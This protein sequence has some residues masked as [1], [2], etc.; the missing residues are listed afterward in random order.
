MKC[1]NCG[2]RNRNNKHYCE[3][4]GNPLGN[5]SYASP[6]RTYKEEIKTKTEKK[7]FFNRTQKIIIALV[8][9][10]VLSVIISAV[11]PPDMNISGITDQLN[12]T[13]EQP[14]TINEPLTEKLNT[15]V[16]IQQTGA[17]V[18]ENIRITS[19]IIDENNNPVTKGTACIYYNDI[20]YSGQVEN[21]YAYITLP[22]QP[23]ES[24]QITVMYEA[25]DEYNPSEATTTITVS[26]QAT[27]IDTQEDN[28]TVTATLQTENNEKITQATITVT[29][30][31]GHTEEKTTDDNG[32][33]TVNKQ[34]GKTLLVYGGNDKYAQ[35]EKTIE[36]EQ[37]NIETKIDANY[38]NNT[39]IIIATLTDIDNNPISG[40]DVTYKSNIVEQTVQTD[41]QGQIEISVNANESKTVWI[42]YYGNKTYNPSNTSISITL[43]Q[44][45]TNHTNQ[46]N[47]THDHTNH[48]NHTNT[49][50]NTKIATK[51]TSQLEDSKL[52]IKLTT[53]DNDAIPD[54]YVEIKLSNGTELTELTDESGE[55]IL[56]L[57][58]SSHIS[59]INIA[60]EGDSKYNSTTKSIY[61]Y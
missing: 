21:G 45:H 47:D 6:I 4:C 16:E 60:Y 28:N 59:S 1:E 20:K 57:D 58:T 7:S 10:L 24:M 34:S 9:I 17:K 42:M 27:R 39:H 14:A 35:C 26:K 30:P 19:K 15:T 48:I 32:Q 13:P 12:N 37:E 11:I 61:N 43:D 56:E 44:N 18:G 23:E 40:A 36:E 52:T 54:E 5:N 31:D 50:N 8:I 38:N 33:I 49:T 25:N 53:E 51:I 29:Y 41:S 22:Q 2:H 55:I 3:K 46:T